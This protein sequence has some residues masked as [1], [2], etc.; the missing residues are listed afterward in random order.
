MS[1]LLQRRNRVLIILILS[2]TVPLQ[3]L[4]YVTQK[5]DLPQKTHL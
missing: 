3:I 1:T 5:A 2:R 4:Y